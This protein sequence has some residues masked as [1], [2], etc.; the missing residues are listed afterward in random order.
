VVVIDYPQRRIVDIT[1][2]HT[3]HFGGQIDVG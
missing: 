2:G 3:S 1:R